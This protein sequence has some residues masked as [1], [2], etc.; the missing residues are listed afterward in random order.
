VV[1]G[2]LLDDFEEQSWFQ[3]PTKQNK[4]IVDH[5]INHSKPYLNPKS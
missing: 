4:S 5:K 2:R 3:C 1:E